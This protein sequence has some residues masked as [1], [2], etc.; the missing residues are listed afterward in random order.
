MPSIFDY[1]HFFDD[2]C[3]ERSLDLHLSFDMP[4]DYET[5]CGTFD[6]ASKTVFINAEH[7]N[8]KPDYEKAFFLF[9]ELRHASQYLCPEH[10]G[11]EIHRSLQYVIGYD[12]TCYKLVNGH[13]ISCKLDGNEDYFTNLYL[14]QPHEVDANT[15]AY[16][17]VKQ[18]YG[19]SKGKYLSDPVLDDI[20]DLNEYMELLRNLSDST[21][22]Y[23]VIAEDKVTHQPIGTCCAVVKDGGSCWD[24]GYCIHPTCWRKGYAKE[25]VNALV[26]FGAQNGIKT[27]LADVAAENAGSCGV[28]RAL[29][30]TPTENGTFRRSGSQTEYKN[31]TFKKEL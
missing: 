25:M 30:F 5:A 13:Y 9:H 1:K 21:D 16:K 23:Y 15:F 8:A 12:G 10:F 19:D 29:G 14:G 31:L 7:L 3:K 26:Q 2:Y 27:V 22:C 4:S 18:L 20:D 11:S 17:Q 24:I 28:M 6:P